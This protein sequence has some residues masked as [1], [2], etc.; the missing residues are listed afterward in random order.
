MFF[1]KATTEAKN[2]RKLL[3]RHEA[4]NRRSAQKAKYRAAHQIL[5]EHHGEK[6]RWRRRILLRPLSTPF[7]SRS[8]HDDGD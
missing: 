4:S 1:A 3:H 8:F 7:G 5:R 6:H 2:L